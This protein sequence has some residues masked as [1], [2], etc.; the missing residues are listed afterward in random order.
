MWKR[1]RLVLHK[2][3]V[4]I[5]QVK[6]SKKIEFEKFKNLLSWFT[7]YCKMFILKFY[8][9]EKERECC[10]QWRQSGLISIDEFRYMYNE[11]GTNIN[12][13]YPIY[14]W[15][16]KIRALYNRPQNKKKK[17]NKIAYAPKIYLERE[18]RL[19]LLKCC[20]G[21]ETA[22]RARIVNLPSTWVSFKLSVQ[23]LHFE[24]L[25]SVAYHLHITQ[26]QFCVSQWR[27]AARE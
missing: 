23:W 16:I 9:R 1:T 14:L 20:V 12:L 24:M 15:K 26:L 25:V 7:E 21:E 18:S 19:L 6:K 4:K 3:Y 22:S 5:N 8:K 10:L 13:W 2:N 27:D 17:K 11:S